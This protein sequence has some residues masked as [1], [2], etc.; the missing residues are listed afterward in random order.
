MHIEI[1]I[2]IILSIIIG[3]YFTDISVEH[4]DFI[5]T[6]FDEDLYKLIMLLIIIYISMYSIPVGIL[7]I[8]A[9]TILML[10]LPK[11]M[12]NFRNSNIYLTGNNLNNFYGP[13]LN[14]CSNYPAERTKSLGSAFYP[15]NT[16]AYQNF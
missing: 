14:R 5:L 12:E 6:L 9:F 11:L 3:K 4:S 15:I 16:D 13:P 2:I 1:F 7:L 8:I 10:T